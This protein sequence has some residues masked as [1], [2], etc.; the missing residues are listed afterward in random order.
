M[1][2]R[3]ELNERVQEWSLREDIIEKDYVI[4]WLLWGIGSNMRLSA[5]WA[6]KGGTCLKKCYLETYRFSEDLDFTVL[7]GGPI[8]S[9]EVIPILQE[10]FQIIYEQSGVDFRVR[11]A[12]LQ[13]RPDGKSAEGRAYYRGPR[14]APEVASIKLD[15]TGAEKIICPTV[16]QRI[17]HPYPDQLPAP[18]T[19]RCYG[20][21]ELF[22]EKLRAMGERSRPRDLYDIVNLFRRQEFFPYA[23][24]VRS[25][26]AQKCESKM[27]EVFTF[28]S[29]ENSPHRMELET[30]WANML[31]HQLP[32]LPPFED[33]WQELPRLF[34]WLNGK[35]TPEEL[36]PIPIAESEES[37]WAPPPTVWVWGQKVPLEPV[38]FAAVN[39]L[40][41]ELGYGGTKR[42]IEP[43]SLRRTKDGLL[44][45]YAVKTATG[46]LRSYR[47]D[48][49]QSI[50]VS[51]VPFRPRHLI[52]F[53]SSGTL[54]A[55][56]T[57]RVSGLTGTLRKSSRSNV[58]HVIE[59]SYCGKRFKRSTYD[60]RLRPH[61]DKG[62]VFSCPGRIGCEVD[63]YYT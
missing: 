63:Q 17:S 60:T 11:P 46:E 53:T 15:L 37:G 21:E 3:T 56:Q 6:F 7:P 58:I 16:L 61:K 20:F 51:N 47:V 2:T 30:E 52:E 43:Y 35:L 62:G 24:L 26:Y 19:I 5:S 59:C 36:K 12:V 28:D 9:D 34:A 4:G 29:L 32:V 18:A 8:K 13:M 23:E 55:P 39:H 57:R 42:Q 22:A 38:R 33:F 54:I 48:R 40:C 31:G 41:V 25:V 27:I 10:I 45:L 14:N 49:I 1:I 50:Q 44:L